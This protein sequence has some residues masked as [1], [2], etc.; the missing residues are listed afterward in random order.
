MKIEK[1]EIAVDVDEVLEGFLESLLSYHNQKNRANFRKEDITKYH[2][3]EILER[4][5]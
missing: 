1:R 2:L 4:L 3:W 5:N